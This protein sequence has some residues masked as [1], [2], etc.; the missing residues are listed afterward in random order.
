LLLE[1]ALQ[2]IDI[3]HPDGFTRSGDYIFELFAKANITNET[4]DE[5]IAIAE[6]AVT[7]L[8]TGN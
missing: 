3:G 7:L 8:V 2:G 1:D 4:K 5:I 6:S